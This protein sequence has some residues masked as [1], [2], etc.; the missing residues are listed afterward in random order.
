VIPN[1]NLS[2]YDDAVACWKGAKMK[3]WKERFI[4]QADKA[5]FPIHT[6][7]KSLSD[8]HKDQLWDG[9]SYAKGVYAFFKYLE[10]KSY[11]IQYRVMLSRYRGRTRCPECKGTRIRKETNYV[12][13]ADT[14]L[15]D[16]L[17]MP[18]VRLKI[19]MDA[20]ELSENDEKI[21]KRVLREVQQRLQFMLDVGLGYL[22]L[23]RS[24]STLSGGETQR[25]NLTRTLG[26]NL[27]DSLYILDEPSVG[28]H[29]QDTTQLIKVLRQLRDL[30]NT[31]IVVE[32][33]EEMIRAADYLIDVG[34]KAGIYGGEIVFQGDAADILNKETLTA[35]YLT[36]EKKV[37]VP[38]HRRKVVNKIEIT[39]AAEHNLK[40]IDVTFPLNAITVV[41]GVSGS[42]KT[43]LV[44]RILFPALYRHIHGSGEKPGTFSGL[45]G[46][47]SRIGNLE[48]I[49]QN[50]LGRSS[51]SNPVTYV[52]AYDAIRSLYA[53]QQL[54]KI[55]GF[56]PKHFSFN[57][58]GGRCEICKG[59][60]IQTIEMQFLADVELICEEC[61]GRRFKDEVLE[62][63]WKGYS[64]H[65]ILDLSVEEAIDVF[66]EHNDIITKLQPLFDVGMG[67]VKLGQSSSTLS[68]GEAQRVKLA[69]YLGKSDR[70]DPILFIFDEPT[71]GLHFDD[72][73]KLMNSLNALVENG[74]SVIIIEHDIDVIKSADWLIE[75]GPGGGEQGGNLV[76]QGVPEGI[77]KVKDSPTAK[78]LKPK[79]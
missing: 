54:S 22:T 50:P 17:L 44:K 28:L 12:K 65:D 19:H 34:P 7:Y 36:G 23:N 47:V 39:G 75:L 35:H 77:V 73:N 72:V 68:G 21:A 51:R 26:S 45:S 15:R 55:R 18:I 46:D 71:T 4:E 5:N 30:G 37:P 69:S 3:V 60:G 43:T 49:D 2:L 63:K 61:D 56:Q 9:T 64:I 20:L 10:E 29:P 38:K 57:V 53:D 32:H 16:L 78:F 67:Y 40:N 8:Y 48:Y 24:S 33:E 66:N 31:V 59:E 70:I 14:T 6:P 42:G 79:L 1:K 52:K 27:T 62:V 76:Y 74:H 58:E 13:I 11:K 41:S 25:I